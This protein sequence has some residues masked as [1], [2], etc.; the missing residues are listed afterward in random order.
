MLSVTGCAELPEVEYFTDRIEL[1]VDFDTPVCEG[2]LAE[3]DAQVERI[4][5][6]LGRTADPRPIRVYWLE[7]GPDTYC[8]EGRTGCYFPATRVLFS[9]S[10]S[11]DHELLHAVVD[12]EGESYFVEEGLA[13]LLSGVGVVYDMGDGKV[14]PT[15]RLRLS[16][17]DYR[18]GGLDYGAAAHFMHYVFRRGGTKAVRQLGLEI[19]KDPSPHQLEQV[20]ERTLGG[21]VAG[22]EADYAAQA[23]RYFPGL[24]H[25]RL[26]EVDLVD[27]MEGVAE[28]GLGCHRADTYGPWVEGDAAMY[29]V[30]RL[31]VPADFVVKVQVDS[32]TDTRV[33]IFDPLAQVGRGRL[34]DWLRPDP[35]IDDAAVMIPSGR[36]EYVSLHVGTYLLVVASDD[37]R[38]VDTQIRMTRTPLPA[39]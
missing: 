25:A 28:V 29:R 10:S 36:T 20:L 4:E 38:T 2:S 11:L 15:Q 24:A 32:S 30:F 31:Q 23:P 16:R 14:S 35:D 12:S 22:I 18:E 21:T 7:D 1:G 27:L 3:L 33:H 17:S 37:T 26:P 34:T 9:K 5:G 13:E 8:D 19:A 6:E 39:Q